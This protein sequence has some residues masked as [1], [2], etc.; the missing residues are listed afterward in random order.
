MK[1]LLLQIFKDIPLYLLCVLLAFFVWIFATMTSD[2]SEVG[3]FSQT[4]TIETIGLEKGELITSGM[5]SS[6]SVNL[7]APNSVWR[8][9]S[10]ERVPGKAVIDV[11]GLEP[12]THQVP[13]NVQIGISPIQIISISPST[14]TLTIEEYETRNYEVVVE[15]T[16]EIPTAFRADPP[17]VNP[18]P[19]PNCR[20]IRY[21]HSV[22]QNQQS[23]CA[24][25]SE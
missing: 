5:P 8:R 16:G 17:V 18:D 7:R 12:G 15:E 6:V 25:C 19:V 22:G 24:S 10:M 14:V 11:T 13:V 20:N 1:K 3:R 2:P 21:C 9:I 4:I 23:F